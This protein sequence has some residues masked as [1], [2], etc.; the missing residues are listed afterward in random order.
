M[1]SLLPREGQ[2]AGY[3]AT[4]F[5]QFNP[6]GSNRIA[7]YVDLGLRLNFSYTT[8]QTI[9]QTQ[10]SN[11]NTTT[12][13]QTATFKGA[14]STG[15]DAGVCVK[16]RLSDHLSFNTEIN[17]S[18]SNFVQDH[19]T[20]IE[21]TVNGADQLN[22]LNTSQKKTDYVKSYT[23]PNSGFD[24]NSP[25]KALRSPLPASTIGVRLGIGIFIGNNNTFKTNSKVTML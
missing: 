23:V 20:L 10:T 1:V 12:T 14:F 4:P 21:Y 25:S 9:D 22:T 16:F 24:P 13:N 8:K 15:L 19:A 2:Y 18:N 6:C 11:N 17:S 7:P 3:S 5:I